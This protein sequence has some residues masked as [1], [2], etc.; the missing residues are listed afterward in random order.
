[1][2]RYLAALAL[3]VVLASLGVASATAQPVGLRLKDPPSAQLLSA[4][5]HA[6][7]RKESSHP[8]DTDSYK[9]IGSTGNNGPTLSP[10]GALWDLRN[11][12]VS[13]DASDSLGVNARDAK[14]GIVKAWVESE[15]VGVI[16]SQDAQCT[17]SSTVHRSCISPSPHGGPSCPKSFS[18]TT[19]ISM[20]SFPEGAN[21][22]T[23]KATDTAGRTG[24][25]S[26]V[27]YIDRTPP[28][29]PGDF[30]LMAYD[31]SSETAV[32][33]WDDSSD[34]SLPDG[35]QGS[36]LAGYDYRWQVDEGEWSAWASTPVPEVSLAQ[37]QSGA[38]I[39][40]EVSSVDKVGNVSDAGTATMNSDDLTE[41]GLQVSTQVSDFASEPSLSSSQSA[42][43]VDLALADSHLASLIGGR[44]YS[45][46]SP[47]V[48]TNS[49]GSVIG[50]A[51]SVNFTTPA[52]SIV[53][54]WPSIRYDDSVASDAPYYTYTANYAATD[55]PSLDVSVDLNCGRVVSIS[56]G[57]EAAVDPD[58][59]TIES[60]PVRPA[61]ELSGQPLND[62]SLAQVQESFVQKTH[63][64]PSTKAI[65]E[66]S[67]LVGP[68]GPTTWIRNV[69][70]IKI[71]TDSFYNY[72][73]NSEKSLSSQNTDNPIN[74]IFWGNSVI[75]KG[76]TQL[77]TFGTGL[78]QYVGSPDYGYLKQGPKWVW[79]SDRGYKDRITCGTDNHYRVYHN[80]GTQVYSPYW[81][82]FLIAEAHQDKGDIP[83]P[84]LCGSAQYGWE[85][86]A[87]QNVADEA[88]RVFGS[89]AVQR[90][91]VFLNNAE[92]R[93]WE[94]NN[95]R[96]NNGLATKIKVCLDQFDEKIKC[97]QSTPTL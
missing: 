68:Q 20:S 13:G 48:W 53:G 6:S 7:A 55:V 32:V 54:D 33:G 39:Y 91:K 28:S 43:S 45:I 12:Y 93:H 77:Y 95:Y 96:W 51:L 49:S 71:G 38:T 41:P 88:T 78:S 62:S 47:V 67:S 30:Q 15:G 89:S 79:D 2:N 70:V 42:R 3:T 69:Q 82:Y 44:S 17:S 26:W 25:T 46:G 34:P 65:L 85:E 84:H 1:M 94:N 37:V 50:A 9:H 40:I 10:S 66:R 72:D 19:S 76:D 5:R 18:F 81:G 80:E 61:C 60:E 87:E 24:A 36:G 14:Y 97:Q 59:V 35:S 75:W 56:P 58:S 73:F 83:I 92:P 29:V 63:S 23:E 22:F 8:R 64:I 27:V 74:L 90:N 86:L 11:Q 21:T 16:D 4:S 57:G 31:G 52:S